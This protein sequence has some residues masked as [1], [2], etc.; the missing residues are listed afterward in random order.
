MTN[1]LLRSLPAADYEALCPLLELVTLPVGRT[2]CEYGGRPDH[3]YFPVNSI[4]SLLYTTQD[5]STTEVGLVGNDGVVGIAL[6]LGGESM[7]H[8]AVVYLAGEA[9]RIRSARLVDEFACRPSLRKH[10][11]RYAQSFLTQ[12][13]QTAV[14]NRLHSVEKRLCRNLLLCHDRISSDDFLMT[15]DFIAT[16]LGGRRESVTVAAGRLQDAGLIRY[17]RGHIHILDRRG[18]EAAAC[19]CYRVVACESLRLLGME[20]RSATSALRASSS[21]IARSA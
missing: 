7:P 15:Q 13:S 16:M 12:I 11:L 5:G 18:L 6:C 21:L 9:F 8:R 10:L 17:T 14:C 4:V 2:L 20:G 19:E 1:R 3:A